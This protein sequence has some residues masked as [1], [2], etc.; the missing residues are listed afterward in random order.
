MAP[1]PTEAPGSPRELTAA[2]RAAAGMPRDLTAAA[3]R[4]R[5]R[6]LWVRAPDTSWQEEGWSFYA[7]GDTP[8]VGFAANWFG[9]AMSLGLLYAGKMGPGG[10]IEPVPDNHPAAEV[11]AQIAAGPAGQAQLLGDLGP[12]LFVAGEGWVVIQDQGRKWDVLSVQEVK[13]QGKSLTCTI[14][15]EQVQVPAEEPGTEPDPKAPVAIRV[16]DSHPRCSREA[17]SPVRRALGLLNE[18]RLLN[19]AVAAVARSQLSGRGVL[20]VP[21]GTKF[22]TKPGENDTEDD[23]I[24]VFLTVAETAYKEPGSA[25]AAVPIVLEVPPELIDKIQRV[26]FEST[27]DELAVKLREEAIR[28]FA[29]GIDIPA[30]ILLGQ[31]GMNHWGAFQIEDQAIK[32]GIEPRLAIVTHALTTQWLHP[33]LV[34]AGVA[35]AEDYVVAADTSALRQRSNR[36]QTAIEVHRSGAISDVALRRETGFDETDAPSEDERR[37]SLIVELVTR[38]PDRLG[39]VLLPLIGIQVPGWT[40]DGATVTAPSGDPD[41][42]QDVDLPVDENPGPPATDGDPPADG[43]DPGL[44]A[45]CDALVTRAL[46]LAGKRL[47]SRRPRSQRG[48]LQEV[49]AAGVHVE[50]DLDPAEID[51]LKLL[52]DAWARLPLV[53]VRYGVDVGCLRG[54]L[55]SYV[56]ELLAAGVPHEWDTMP[57]VLRAPCLAAA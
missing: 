50:V 17:D 18:L 32:L 55:D 19:A 2:T 31:G 42:G 26:T 44:M 40:A 53:A 52:D 48:H 54:T 10:Q 6:K 14:G 16:W 25:A 46:E 36:P 20:F 41:Q 7:D 30:E 27:F 28:R 3:E 56:R 34:A 35:D 12:H 51:N 13:P 1:A 38:S 22:P 21:Q 15:D 33:I 29:A 45:A 43:P 9:S 47:R 11:V 37:R 39:P 5:A 8:E 49:D 24:E 23:L 57:G 4:Y